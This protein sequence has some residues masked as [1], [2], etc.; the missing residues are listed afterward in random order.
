MQAASPASGE[1]RGKSRRFA[2]RTISCREGDLYCISAPYSSG[3]SSLLNAILWST[4]AQAMI[5]SGSP[6]SASPGTQV[7]DTPPAPFAYQWLR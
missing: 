3:R 2:F 5:L 7:H 6:S 1:S 4:E